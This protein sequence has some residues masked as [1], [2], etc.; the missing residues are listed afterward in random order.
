MKIETKKAIFW[1]LVVGVFILGPCFHF[2]VNERGYETPDNLKEIVPRTV[3]TVIYGKE[4]P[5]GGDPSVYER[6]MSYNLLGGNQDPE[7]AQAEADA[8]AE[9]LANWKANFPYKPIPIQTW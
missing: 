1:G 6:L 7:E 4:D 5:V 3:D 8:E 9:R 2:F